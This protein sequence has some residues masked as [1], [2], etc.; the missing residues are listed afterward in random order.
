MEHKIA[1][2]PVS[3]FNSDGRDLKHIRLCY[4]KTEETLIQAAEML[5]KI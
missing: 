3:V 1:T 4:A 5:N 2:I